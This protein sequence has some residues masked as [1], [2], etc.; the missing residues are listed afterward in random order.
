MS[1]VWSMNAG[2]AGNALTRSMASFSV[3]IACGLAA[4]SKPMWLSE[5]CRNVKPVAA[6]CGGAVEQAER[7]WHAARYRPKHACAR[8]EHAFERMTAADAVP[9]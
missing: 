2:F 8:P 3:S 1:P 6:A 4:L 7:L 5:I 9:S